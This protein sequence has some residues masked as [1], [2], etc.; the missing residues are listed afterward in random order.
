MR[1]PR[2]SPPSSTAGTRPPRA[3]PLSA[4]GERPSG[5]PSASGRVPFV[6]LTGGI[7]A[8][9]SA[10]L[11][12]L[13]ELGA[14]TLSSDAIVHDLLEGEEMREALIQRY[15]AAVAPGGRV[16]RAKLGQMA[17]ADP[18]ERTWLERE[19]W[20]KVGERV[21]QWYADLVERDPAPRA[22]VVEVPLLFE[23]GMERIFDSTVAVV[24]REEVRAERAGARGH[25]AVEERT[26]RQLGQDEKSARADFIARNDGSLAELRE[27]LSALLDRIVG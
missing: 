26:S 3:S 10:A 13:E 7:A 27:A 4:L 21:A 17:F 16:D 18:E 1:K 8:G 25:A 9:K 14:A 19:L 22:A 11:A 24:A 20:P 5:Q 2:P 6:G 15:G 23:S 12:A